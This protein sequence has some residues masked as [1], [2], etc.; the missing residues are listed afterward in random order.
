[1]HKDKV[2]L[3]DLDNPK[4]ETPP[5][6]SWLGVVVSLADGQHTIQQLLD[7]MSEHY[8]GKPPDNLEETIE[9]VIK[10][11]TQGEV[12]KL[13]DEAF[14]LPYYLSRSADKLD[15]EMAKQAMADDGYRQS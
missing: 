3:V 15:I 13:A 9:S 11:L 7:Y 6:E 5:L 1:M 4:E 8:G 14:K 10:R 2:M 12:I